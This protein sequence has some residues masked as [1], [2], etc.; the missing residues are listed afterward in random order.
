MIEETVF[1]ADEI[2]KAFRVPKRRVK[3]WIRKGKLKG[4]LLDSFL[5]YNAEAAALVEFQEENPRYQYAV[6]DL[7]ESKGA[8]FL[9]INNLKRG[10]TLLSAVPALFYKPGYRKWLIHH[11]RNSRI[12]FIP[13]SIQIALREDWE[14]EYDLKE[15]LKTRSRVLAEYREQLEKLYAPYPGLKKVKEEQRE[16]NE[17]LEDMA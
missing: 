6:V 12:P 16:L 1:T 2:A 11:I 13:G 10:E 5:N 8:R 7:L 4:Y 3:S 15:E 14:K 17:I 9:I